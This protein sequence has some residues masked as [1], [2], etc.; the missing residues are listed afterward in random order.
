MQLVF[1]RLHLMLHACIARF[2]MIATVALFEKLFKELNKLSVQVRA[3]TRDSVSVCTRSHC[4]RPHAASRQQVIHN[5]FLRTLF[6]F[7][8]L[9]ARKL[10]VSTPQE[11]LTSAMEELASILA[12][13]LERGSA[14]M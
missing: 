10:R 13:T 5:H 2:D 14:R 4:P 9:A 1:F 3:C 12:V 8:I 6:M 11:W 7:H